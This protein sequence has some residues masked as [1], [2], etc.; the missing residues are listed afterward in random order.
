MPRQT[1]NQIQPPSGFGNLSYGTSIVQDFGTPV[2]DV[3]RVTAE[4]FQRHETNRVAFAELEMLAES[5]KENIRKEH[6]EDMAIVDEVVSEIGSNIANYIEGGNFHNA[7]QVLLTQYKKYA[8][9][10]KLDGAK[11][12]RIK[13]IALMDEIDKLKGYSEDDKIRIKNIANSKT[14]NK[15]ITTD[16]KGNVVGGY[17]G[18]KPAEY[19]D[20]KELIKE[21]A[22]NWKGDDIT[23]ESFNLATT[24]S[25]PWIQ[26]MIR[27]DAGLSGEEYV[28]GATALL[29]N[30]D[31][32]MAYLQSKYIIDNF[33]PSTG[34]IRNVDM[35]ELTYYNFDR[36]PAIDAKTKKEIPELDRLEQARDAVSGSIIRM[37]QE[38]F[39]RTGKMISDEQA[40]KEL[41]R[42]NYI[43]DNINGAVMSLY[44]PYVH[45]ISE[46][47]QKVM[48]D[49]IYKAK[50]AK[51][52]ETTVTL[53]PFGAQDVTFDV[54]K[55]RAKVQEAQAR[56]N[57]LDAQIRNKSK[58]LS[59]NPKDELLQNELDGLKK[60]RDALSGTI[61]LQKNVF[62]N[63]MGE[64]KDEEINAVLNAIS[65]Y[66]PNL[67]K[68]IGEAKLR[69][70]I[71]TGNTTDIT[72][73]PIGTAISKGVGST[74][75]EFA[76]PIANL[77]GGMI[78]TSSSDVEFVND[79]INKFYENHITRAGANNA[80]YSSYMLIQADGGTTDQLR[81][82]VL[83]AIK[84]GTPFETVDGRSSVDKTFQEEIGEYK[85][86]D[87][88][89][90][91]DT[92]NNTLLGV[93][94]Y[95]DKDNNVKTA[96][97]KPPIL[98][99]TSAGIYRELT[100]SS[101]NPAYNKFPEY[102]NVLYTF[103][104][105]NLA[106]MEPV[107]L[108]A[109]KDSRVIGDL[110]TVLSELNMENAINMANTMNNPIILK[111]GGR[112]LVI[113]FEKSYD[114][115]KMK[116]SYNLNPKADDWRSESGTQDN[117]QGW[118]PIIYE[119]LEGMQPVN[120]NIM[121]GR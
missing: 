9:N 89:F 4:L 53:S 82:G 66:T 112:G 40:M 59:S 24:G 72:A 25:S 117:T 2:E 79:L 63:L 31:K 56:L 55:N 49:D 14:F 94:S 84:S 50:F 86:V 27:R 18:W 85:D 51:A 7:S 26:G 12:A 110:G 74:S 8:T 54:K 116:Y 105:S 35:R 99:E 97:I 46:R 13:Q 44:E 93:V 71:K 17:T 10:T 95:T 96:M 108:S 88:H 73:N 91:A 87:F 16:E 34:D 90:I 36:I 106:K 69:E 75:A 98:A 109:D 52:L 57:N 42:N 3:Q 11:Q 23:T 120:T 39:D 29:M 118:Q 38:Y 48:A 37:Q 81:E 58:L 83:N 68:S 33:D 70:A 113:A 62:D 103:G 1:Y 6:P 102:A 65:K 92:K 32:Y 67:Y 5:D 80:M 45:T 19:V 76:K 119:I 21:F 64:F 22:S 41:H 15:A 30:D 100:I 104:T 61:A 78:G 60:E 115:I 111:R 28:N 77:I 20:G 107:Y 114:G 101:S 47:R 121:L 43:N